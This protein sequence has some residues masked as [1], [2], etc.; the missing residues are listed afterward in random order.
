MKRLYSSLFALALA[1]GIASA[2]YVVVARET[3]VFDGPAAKDAT[4][5]MS[6]SDVVAKP[7]MVFVKESAQSGW[8][9]V[10]YLTGMRAYISA[11]MIASGSAVTLPAAG[12]YGIANGSS[13]V[14]ITAEGGKYT[15]RDAKATYSGKADNNAVI[16]RDVC[17]NVTYS[18]VVMNG[19]TYVYDYTSLGW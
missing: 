3:R 10:E 8:N 5:A 1:C 11:D 2:E 15:L 7:G 19:K 17:G 4:A 14:T 16:F 12:E 6:G 9:K 13:K 18:A